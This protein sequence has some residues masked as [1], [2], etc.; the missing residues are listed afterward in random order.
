MLS[1]VALMNDKEIFDS[2]VNNSDPS[3]CKNLDR[4]VKNFNQKLWN[5]NINN[6]AFTISLLYL[7]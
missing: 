7:F 5:D 3:I 6:I 4:K 1:K 2:I